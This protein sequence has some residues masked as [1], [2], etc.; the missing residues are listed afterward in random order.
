MKG[1]QL[2][3]ERASIGMRRFSID[4]MVMTK[5]DRLAEKIDHLS[6]ADL[7]WLERIEKFFIKHE[8]LTENQMR[9]LDSIG[10]R[11]LSELPRNLNS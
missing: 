10:K 6:Y 3:L 7:V 9:V 8:Y 2:E 11:I 1:K 4:R 5:L